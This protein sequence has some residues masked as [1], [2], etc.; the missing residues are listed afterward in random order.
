MVHR[1]AAR[2]SIVTGQCLTLRVVRCKNRV[3]ILD[4]IEVGMG[5][6]TALQRC[7]RCRSCSPGRSPPQRRRVSGAAVDAPGARPSP[8]PPPIRA[9]GNFRPPQL[10]LGQPISASP[11]RDRRQRAERCHGRGPRARDDCA[12]ARAERCAR[13]RRRR[14]RPPIISAS[15]SAGG[16]SR[17]RATSP[18]SKPA[19]LPG[20]REARR[21]R[22][23]LFAATSCTGRVAVRRRS[24]RRRSSRRP[25]PND[26]A[27]RSISAA[28]I[29]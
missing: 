26:E 16:G 15:L 2:A 24:Q 6:A 10:R 1:I 3:A 25:G 27:I 14:L 11:R 23:Q 22:P 9:R 13:R 20:G 8:P 29:R 18:R 5:A 21:R 7:L 28:P 12:E 19:L 4:A 17:F